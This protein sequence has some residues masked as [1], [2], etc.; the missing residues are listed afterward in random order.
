MVNV[1]NIPHSIRL[2]VLGRLRREMLTKLASSACDEIHQRILA[3][4][5]VRL[6]ITRRALIL[7]RER[8]KGREGIERTELG[9]LALEDIAVRARQKQPL[10]LVTWIGPVAFDLPPATVIA[11]LFLFLLRRC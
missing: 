4:C 7:G 6:V 9:A 5:P 10:A 3:S 11:G 8:V 2:P 1:C